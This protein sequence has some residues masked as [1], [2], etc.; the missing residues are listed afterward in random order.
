MKMLL[1]GI[2]VLDC[3]V[4]QQGPVATAMMGDLG[5]EV[6]KIEDP[7]GGDPARGVMKMWGVMARLPD[8]RNFYLENNNRNKKGMTLDLK[9]EKGRQILYELVEKS[10]VFVHNYRL[11]VPKKLGCDYETLCKYNPTLIYVQAS[12]YGPNGPDSLAPAF[13]YTGQAR[14]GL[15]TAMVKWECPPLL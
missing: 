14:S 12:G 3:T 2:R 11:D 13:D 8:G 6:I 5:A 10:D 4:W 15:M 9:K 7:V 1:E